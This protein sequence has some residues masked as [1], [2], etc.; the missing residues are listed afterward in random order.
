MAK[1]TIQLDDAASRRLVKLW[2]DDAGSRREFAKKLANVKKEGADKPSPSEENAADTLLKRLEEVVPGRTRGL[3]VLTANQIAKTLKITRDDFLA[4]L[5]DVESGGVL[6]K[7]N[8][9][10][11]FDL[12]FE[13]INS[14]Q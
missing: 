8:T 5:L 7:L 10:E 2:T 12:F 13:Y 14:G 1:G 9:K 11:Y 3:T 6:S 4:K